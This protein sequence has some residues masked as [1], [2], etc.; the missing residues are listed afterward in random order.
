MSIPLQQQIQTLLGR[1]EQHSTLRSLNP[2]GACVLS[3]RLPLSKILWAIAPLLSFKVALSINMQS[4]YEGKWLLCFE[5]LW[6]WKRGTQPRKAKEKGK[7][8]LAWLIQ[9]LSQEKHYTLQCQKKYKFS[10]NYKF[11]VCQDNTSLV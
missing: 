4:H 1:H 5:V 10:Y 2:H 11:T 7:I 3:C 9:M 8:H 6:K